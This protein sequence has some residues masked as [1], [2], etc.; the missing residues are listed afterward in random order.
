MKEM[1]GALII[2]PFFQ[3]YTEQTHHWIAIELPKNEEPGS[4]GAAHV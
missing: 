3:F 4:N 1:T 2:P